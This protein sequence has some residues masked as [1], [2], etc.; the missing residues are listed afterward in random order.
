MNIFEFRDSVIDNYKS[1]SRSFTKIRAKDIRA[2]V[3]RECYENQ[4]FWPDPIIQINPSYKQRT[5]V[6]QL[7]QAGILEPE[8]ADIFQ[9]D[10]VPMNLYQHQVQA[11]DL[12]GRNESFVV[13]T[14]T[15]SGKSMCFFIPLVNRILREKKRDPKPRTRAIILYPMNAL[16]NS[17]LEEIKKFLGENAAGLRIERYTGQEKQAQRENLQENP[18]DILLTNYMMLELVLMRPNDRRLVENCKGLEFLILDELHTYRGRQGS[19]VA[20]LV[21]RLRT[22][23]EADHLV[24]IGTSAT[25]ASGGSRQDQ[26]EV[27]ARF[28]SRIFATK[29]ES[30]NVICETL[31]RQTNVR[32]QDAGKLHEVVL[33]AAKGDVGLTSAD[34]IADNQLAIWVEGCLSINHSNMR[35]KP[36]PFS[37]IVE[38][39]SADA[40]VAKEDAHAAFTN[41]LTH[42]GGEKGLVNDK[43]RNPFPF[44]L[45]QFISGPGKM[46]T[47]L[48]AP[49]QRTL[50]LDGQTMARIGEETVP[51][52]EV[53]FCK[54]CGEEYIPVW[55]KK[56]SEDV[57]GG[58]L[59]RGIDELESADDDA[60]FGYLCPVKGD[61]AYQGALETLPDDWLEEN[62]SGMVVKQSRRK[63]VPQLFWVDKHGT[64]CNEGEGTPFW[65][66]PEKFRLCVNCL[67]TF[68]VRAKD[69]NRLIGLSGEGRSSAT[70]IL[71]LQILRLLY[72]EGVKD[73]KHDY[74][75]LLGF[76]DNRQDAAL[77]AG[78]FND[79]V[80]QLI[81]RGGLVA[82]LK[83]E[84]QALPLSEIVN[85]IMVLF[86]LTEA[87]VEEHA[88]DFLRPSAVVGGNVL[89][90]AL[91][92]LR[93][94]LSYRLLLDLE[95]RNLYTCPSL[96]KLH[97][98]EIKYRGLDELAAHPV[99]FAESRVL[100]ALDAKARKLFLLTLLNE[101][102]R[103]W[104]IASRFF[105]D[106]EQRALQGSGFR[107]LNARW[108]LFTDDRKLTGGQDATFDEQWRKSKFFNGFFLNPQSGIVRKLRRLPFW[109]TV[110]H[111]GGFDPTSGKALV[112]LI[113]EAVEIL[114]RAGII[115]GY[116]GKYGRTYRIEE[117]AILW[118]A[119]HDRDVDVND[120][121]RT[122]YENAAALLNNASCD[123]FEFEAE[124]HT[125]Q[126]SSDER[127]IF[128]MRF[129]ASPDDREKW[130]DEQRGKFRRLPVLYC[131]P[132]MELGIDI[133]ALNYV[134]MRNVPPTSANYVQRAGRAG[135]SGQQ[136][137]SLTYCASQSPHDQW[138]F[139]HPEDM[140]QGIVKEPTLDL[141]NESLIKTHLHSLWMT[142]VAEKTNLSLGDQVHMA[143][144]LEK[145]EDNFPLLPEIAQA[146]EAPEVLDRAIALG[147]AFMVQ[148]KD[149]IGDTVPHPDVFVESTMRRAAQ[150]FNDAFNAWRALYAATLSQIDQAYK[151]LR[152]M[153]S[154]QEANVA[155][156]RRADAEQQ[157]LLLT[158]G[159]GSSR[160]SNNDFYVY[161]Y[162]ANQGFL[163]GYSFPA[164]PMMAWIPGTD[165]RNDE[166]TVLSRARFLGISEFGPGNHIYHRGR[167]YRIERVKLNSSQNGPSAQAQLPTA[168]AVV[169]PVCGYA[170]VVNDGSIANQCE[171]CGASL[172]QEDVLP[173]L[174]RVTMVETSE[175]ER[176]SIED[177][178]RQSLGYDMQTLY[179]FAP[180][181]GGGV[182][183]HRTLVKRGAETLASL[184]YAPSA[185]LWRVNLGWKARKHQ[186][187]KGFVI[188]P[189]TG[190]WDKS[191]PDTM[192]KAQ[193][194]E[195]AVESAKPKQLVIP[196][197]TDVR[198]IL[199]LRPYISDPKDQNETMA[200]LQAALKRALEQHY[201]IE[202]SE[203]FVEPLP[204]RVERTGLIIYESGEG[205]SGILRDLG[206]NPSSLK[207][208]AGKALEI[209]HYEKKGE[210]WSYE[211]LKDAKPDCIRGCYECLLTYYNQP[212]HELINRR[213]E[214]A[215]QFLT[216]LASSDDL[217]E[218]K[219]SEQAPEGDLPDTKWERFKHLLRT[220]GL[221]LPDKEQKTF[222]RFS[223]VFDGAYSS[224]R[225]LLSTASIA[226]EVIEDL[227]DMGWTVIDISDEGAW[228]HILEAHADLFGR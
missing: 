111:V 128:E 153:V 70:S 117:N 118:R 131:S 132:T 175:V 51:L 113:K 101:F 166:A 68:D 3:Q 155:R 181:Q 158:G 220:R 115:S 150:D 81:L 199:I 55:A 178:N 154:K 160:S 71:T 222:R 9:F 11:I 39:L 59:P 12:A 172:S 19:D 164:M 13:T 112:G 98:L 202:S 95:D 194:A 7:V 43:G 195:A 61:Q 15:G 63:Y 52:Y 99:A 6:E 47:T 114:L 82:V 184:T 5:N 148:M 4:R 54:E 144:D 141:T 204:N 24:C 121:Y 226:S 143:L 214:D 103:R 48:E 129:R 8:C 30:C 185:T 29:I 170:H 205:G 102:R 227:D 182:S 49:N 17:Q 93:F 116:E 88:D 223:P 217:V 208:V 57:Y 152:R 169:C 21:R 110:G 79:F 69:K 58:F 225:V 180:M 90:D 44:K 27:V 122:L 60:T 124:E 78:H 198:N 126:V 35:A 218:E 219:A 134:Y 41:F 67:T 72:S 207:A 213:N 80:N 87:S 107:Y 25:M 45:H 37:E 76:A 149:E 179:R 177:E 146:I 191:N 165:A 33:R 162:L 228:A 50:T 97:L 135:R 1:F 74:R 77:Q 83:H 190:Y 151:V 26:Q 186:K 120:F 20:A 123:L 159:I 14:G 163:P 221:A 16:A 53:H 216:A 31:E 209:M 138:F 189:M 23:F 127:E 173:G 119:T 136:A 40:A 171:N 42:F 85:R 100:S 75:K 139:Q 10:G 62:R 196:F 142:A 38:M 105:S 22:Q 201:Q 64:R 2:C 210:T 157:K 106:E 161:R 91:E 206:S 215:L 89:R 94:S 193:E 147:K 28:A 197:V 73:P 188:N 167:I 168:T 84:S 86:R 34:D 176:I 137:L 109:K 92:A 56:S 65:F 108:N 96:E 187:T 18:P 224:S 183:K 211:D 32:V 133:S 145:E 140:V 125:A 130:H 46:Y 156:S 212:E 203:L 66:L 200:T 192:T 174:F 104:C 36:L